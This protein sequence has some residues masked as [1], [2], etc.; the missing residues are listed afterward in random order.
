MKP[1]VAYLRRSTDRQEQSL[2]DQEKAIRKYAAEHD[3]EIVR[4]YQDDAVSGTSTNGRRGFEQMFADSEQ[5]GCAF[6]YI[7]VYDVKRF[8]R[9]DNDEAGYHRHL[10]R[11]RGIEVIYV[12]ENFAGNDTDDL[13]CSTKQWLA[14]QEA[15]E[16]SKVT[17]RGLL[18][19]AER[20][21][22]LG[23]VPPFGYDIQ[24]E[25]NDGI[26]LTRVRF[27]SDGRKEVYDTEG[28]LL[29]VVVRRERVAAS[30]RDKARLVP[31]S[32]ER[33]ELVRRI[34]NMYVREGKGLNAIAESL[35]GKGIPS[36]RARSGSKSGGGSWSI[37]TLWSI[38]RNP[39]YTGAMVWN[40][41]A[42]GKFHRV[43]AGRTTERP[44][45]EFAKTHVSSERDW[46]VV[47]GAHEPLIDRETF[48]AA[49]RLLKERAVKHCP[50]GVLRVGHVKNSPYLL[51]GLMRCSRC[52]YA[53]QGYSSHTRRHRKSGE[54][55]TPV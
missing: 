9:G 13:V 52:G 5:P 25:S 30:D 21:F 38:L 45:S 36:P 31:S 47:P 43:E 40:R 20:G 42:K 32:L 37:G 34:F 46:I 23:G 35:N 22:W 44:R 1:A 50:G 48:E 27:L 16:L 7:L 51:T 4:V 41:R 54:M 55:S 24:Y 39:I 15:K 26:A 12:S 53:Y 3:L 11:Q 29:R 18:T 10:L 14:R 2:P 19:S 6:R 49:Q 28:K 8:S 17:F 33:V